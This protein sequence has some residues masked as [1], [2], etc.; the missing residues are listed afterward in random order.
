MAITFGKQQDKPIA[1]FYPR[2][3]N[4][5]DSTLEI[6]WKIPLKK[7]KATEFLIKNFILSASVDNFEIS[8]VHD[9]SITTGNLVVDTVSSVETIPIAHANCFHDGK[10]LFLFKDE[11][12]PKF[13]IGF[14]DFGKI[15]KSF[16]GIH[17]TK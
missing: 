4:V 2:L 3:S 7:T 14:L 10:F 17:V 8:Q 1:F 13:G 5:G 16:H 9:K 11:R 15:F 6:S 12:L